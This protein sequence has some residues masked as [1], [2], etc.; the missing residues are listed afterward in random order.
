KELTVIDQTLQEDY[1]NLQGRSAILDSVA[2][3][4]EN[5]FLNVEI[6]GENDGPSQKGDGYHCGLLD[7]NVLTTGDLF[8][9]L[10]D[11]YVIFIPKT[12]VL[13]YNLQIN[14]QNHR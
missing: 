6:Q 8:A 11:T 9:N 14:Q 10:P 5:N 2:K 13:G 7:M 3:D 1:K 12:D 4:A